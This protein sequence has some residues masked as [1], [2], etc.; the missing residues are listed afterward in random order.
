MKAR[1]VPWWI[2]IKSRV[3]LFGAAMS[4]LPILFLGLT[5]FNAARLHLEGSIQQQNFERAHSLADELQEFVQNMADSLTHVTSTNA[6]LLVGQDEVARA[7]VLGTLLRKEPYLEKLTVAGRDLRIISQVSRREVIFPQQRPASLEKSELSDNSTFAVSPV[8]FAADG[9][10]EFYL[11]V[12]IQ[13]P[14]TRQVIG[15]LQA[16]TD[17]KGMVTKFTNLRIGQAGHVYLTDDMGNLIGHTDFSYVLRREQVQKYPAVEDF[18][19]GKTPS[20]RGSE[21]LNAEGVKVIGLYA[22]VG[23]PNWAVVIEQPIREAYG[24]ISQFAFKLL[25][26]TLVTGF[27]VT[28]LS[29]IFGLK[30]TRPLEHLEGEV[31]GII[32]SG[33]LEAS[34]P[35]QTQDEIGSLVRSFNQ[36]LNMLDEKGKKLKAEKELLTTVVNGIGAGMALLDREKRIIWWNS[37]F[38]AWFGSQRLSQVPCARVLAGDGI[39]CLPLDSGRIVPLEVNGAQRYVRQMYYGLTPENQED[40]AYLVLLED[41]TQEVEMEARMIETDKMAAVGLLASGVAHEINNP[42]AII[43]AHSED[44]YD[45]LSENPPPPAEMRDILS[46][47]SGQVARCK[48]ITGQLL[49]FARKGK[50]G[51]DFI[52]IGTATVQAISLIKHQAKQK[53]IRI[54][55]T[56]PEGLIVAGNENEWQQVVLNIMGNALDASPE[57]GIIEV[58]GSSKGTSAS[59]EVEDHGQGIPAAQVKKAFE[60]FFTTKPVGQ[61]TGLGLFV[62]YGIVRKMK[63]S[64]TLE[65]EE[66]MGTKVK[67][68][69]PSPEVYQ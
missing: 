14:Y 47:I 52:D 24:P 38:G 34:I 37:I 30:L 61:G 57:G 20:P 50:E 29:V 60:P 11:T 56:L 7:S 44:L 54:E 22:P 53:K 5:S 35:Q 13:N 68:T 33:N 12:A 43:S 8:F 26:I 25:G 18:L 58:R 55:S 64:I 2:R 46:I 65:S 19:A 49:H 1:A 41:V 45:R 6:S 48:Q 9:R 23:K 21:Y 51:Q 27:L 39:D 28:L 32:A 15:Y 17:L 67:I 16:E 4:I 63:G 36:L 31:R 62:S 40:A 42:L 3:L 59:I 10:P 66:G 69:L